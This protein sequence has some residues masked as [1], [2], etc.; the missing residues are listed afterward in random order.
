MLKDRKFWTGL[1]AGVVVAGSVGLLSPLYAAPPSEADYLKAM[2]LV[3]GT[4]RDNGKA[5]QADLAAIKA[6]A[7]RIDKGITELRQSQ[8]I[9]PN[10]PR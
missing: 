7:E 9:N 5:M 2:A 4:M 8:G 6:S 3:M 1:L 10:A